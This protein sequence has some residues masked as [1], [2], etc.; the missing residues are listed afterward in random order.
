M[1]FFKIVNSSMI[2]KILLSP[3]LALI[4]LFLIVGIRITDPAFIESV[5]LRYFD[6][7]ITSKPVTNL[8][9]YTVNIDE[10]TL[11]VYGQ[12]PFNRA[13][14][15]DIIKNM[16]IHNAGLTVLNVSMPEE[17]RQGGDIA[18][19]K[20]LKEFPVIL[21]NIP[22][23]QSKNTSRVSGSAVIGADYL[24]RIVHYPGLIAN[25]PVLENAAIGVGTVNTFPEIDGVNRR[26]PLIVSVDG[27]LYPS[28]SMETLRVLAD[29][30]T[31]QVKLNELGVE[32]M[33][34]PKF[35]PI[36]TDN[37]GRIWIDWSQSAISVSL[38]N[39]P[40]DF[41]GGVV[42]IGPTA[43]G[44][45][46]PV[47]TSKGAVFPHEVQASV[48][49]TMI[50][51]VTIQRPNYADGAENLALLIAGIMLL[52]LTRW[53]YVGLS[54]VVILSVGSVFASQYLFTT[55]LYLFDIT[56]FVS[57]V[58]IVSLHAYGA[59]F[60]NEFFQKLQ[61]KKQFGTYLSPDYVE[62][63][64]KNPEL[65]KLGGESK[66]LTIYF[67][68]I[69]SFTTISEHYKTDPMGLTNLITRYMDKMLPIIMNNE[70]TV[71]KL[72]GDAIMAWWG[73]P[74]DVE[75]QATK[76]LNAAKEMEVALAELNIEL[77]SEGKPPLQVGAGISTGTVFVGNMGS[78]DRFS[79]DI[80]GDEV[81]LAARLEGQTKNY[82]V[83]LIISKNT[84]DKRKS[85]II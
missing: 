49:G 21:P 38:T 71:G 15:S 85:E 39:L 50:N 46:N 37:L 69:R 84:L 22:A 40:Q 56:V 7:L 9:I 53:L 4:S 83:S 70:G 25:V 12:W 73:A 3:W 62:K 33:R 13:V 17:D 1:D 20:T 26:I 30:S 28:L 32:K 8:N 60:L 59:K 57:G 58:I 79:Y 11:N 24:D 68:D 31:F 10:A 72:I 16:Y 75:N 41:N 76:A 47:P 51:G 14:Y 82:G 35:G 74:L 42:I 66:E 80:L 61:I 78:K 36:A 5:R 29:D 23:Q 34:I 67:S 45:S 64:Q 63:L 2:K 44:I 77:V 55:Y 48:I 52:F 18:L 27:K 65:L 19:S 6:T 54:A 81:N 43:A